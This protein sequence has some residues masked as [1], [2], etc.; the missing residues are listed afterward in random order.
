MLKAYKYRIYPTADQAILMSKHFGCCRYLYNW[1]LEE[2]QKHYAKTKK[3][4]S[5][6]DLVKKLPKLKQEKEWLSEVCAQS[7]QR[8][9]LN[10]DVAFTNFFKHKSDFPKFKSKHHKQS[11][12]YPQNVKVDFDKGVVVLPLFKEVKTVFSRTFKGSIKTCTVSRSTTGKYF[13]SIL[14]DD[15]EKLPEKPVINPNSA[16]GIDLGL[17]DFVTLS[18]GTK[19]ANPKFGLDQRR[20]KRLQRQLARRIKGGKNREKT[21]LKITKEYVKVTIQRTDFLQ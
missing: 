7:M 19:V 9:V 17:I 2:K 20:L 6:F 3:S 21:K 16:I 8:S 14:V 5:G 13:V 15:F 1:A 11:F 18:D 4:I 12:Q 10:L